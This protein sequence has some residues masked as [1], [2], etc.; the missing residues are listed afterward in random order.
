MEFRQI[1]GGGDVGDT[2]EDE[3]DDGN[4]AS[5]SDHPL[6]EAVDEFGRVV[7]TAGIDTVFRKSARAGFT[8]EDDMERADDDFGGHY[9][10]KSDKGVK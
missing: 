4:D 3:K 2:A 6:D 1:T 5:D 8:D 10:G 7:N 9:D